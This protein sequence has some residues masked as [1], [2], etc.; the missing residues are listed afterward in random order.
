SSG[1][2]VARQEM[3][4]ARKCPGR[5]ILRQPPASFGLSR[6]FLQVIRA[7]SLKAIRGSGSMR[8][9]ARHVLPLPPTQTDGA[10]GLHPRLGPNSR[11]SW[12]ATA[13]PTAAG[14]LEPG[15]SR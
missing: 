5:T 7:E 3:W 9:L 10:D 8:R 1:A 2:E 13:S 11:P 14:H 15:T 6:H 4:Q 12:A